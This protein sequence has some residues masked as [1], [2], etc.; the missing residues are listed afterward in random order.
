MLVCASASHTLIERIFGFPFQIPV[1]QRQGTGHSEMTS[2]LTAY[3]A[4]YAT[5]VP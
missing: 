5:L 3:L 2:T 1:L 4:L